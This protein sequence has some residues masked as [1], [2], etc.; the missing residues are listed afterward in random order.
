VQGLVRRIGTGADTHAWDDNWLP[1]DRFM[2]PCACLVEDQC[3]K[4]VTSSTK[5]PGTG[6]V[7]SVDVEI[8][9]SIP[10]S[11]R[12]QS[13]FWAWHYEKKGLFSV[14]SAYQMLVATGKIREA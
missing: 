5:L 9:K 14:R 3:C 11:M 7:F 13:D 10:I 4:C 8:I 2:R 12:A 1:R 6:C